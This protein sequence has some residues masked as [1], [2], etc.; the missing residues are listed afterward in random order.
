MARAPK[1]F[2]VGTDCSGMEAPLMALRDLEVPHRHSFSCDILPEART[3]ITANFPN[4]LMYDDITTRKN[5]TAPKVD[6]YVAGF[7]CQPF[8]LQGMQQGFEDKKG[9]GEIFFK[10]LEYIEMAKPKLFILENVKGLTIINKG[11]YFK[12]ILG[13]LEQL[14]LYSIHHSVM[15]TK[16][17]G[18]PQSRP[19][20]Y[21]VGIRKD[22]DDGSFEFPDSVKCPNIE[23]LMEKRSTSILLVQQGLPPESASTARKNVVQAKRTLV[24]KG[25]NPDRDPIVMDID[26]TPSR[27]GWMT[28]MSPCI[29]RRRGNGHWLMNRGRRMYLEEMMRLQGMDHTK[30]VVA[31]TPNQLGCQLGNTMSQNVVERVLVRALPACGLV[32]H[33]V[34][35]DRWADGSGLKYLESLRGKKFKAIE[36]EDWTAKEARRDP[37]VACTPVKQPK[38]RVSLMVTTPGRRRLSV[39]GNLC[40][41]RRLSV[42]G[43]R[44]SIGTP[45][46]K[47]KRARSD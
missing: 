1:P 15:N 37:S 9:R 26:S 21:I 44:P 20:V 23:R 22:V 36:L 5:A 28:G 45:K 29:T 13:S 18:V 19:R 10:V 41:K 31:V 43:R 14:G 35:N 2:S 4:G 40:A 42:K 27:A 6:L 17:H 11:E 34:L 25:S 30:F 33:G 39:D 16:N 24:R 3:T 32:R 47:G 12:S 38:R 7:P 8:S 46:P